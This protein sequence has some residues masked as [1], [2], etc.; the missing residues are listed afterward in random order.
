MSKHNELLLASAVVEYNNRD[1]DY[2]NYFAEEQAKEDLHNRLSAGD[3]YCTCPVCMPED[4][5]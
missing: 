3:G 4:D 2:D 1:M 5:D